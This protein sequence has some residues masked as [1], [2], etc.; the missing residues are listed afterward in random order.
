MECSKAGNEELNQ[1]RTTQAGQVENGMAAW[2]GERTSPVEQVEHGLVESG[3]VSS[4][5]VQ[6]SK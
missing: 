1:I 4:C 2:S 6:Q 3:V 5:G